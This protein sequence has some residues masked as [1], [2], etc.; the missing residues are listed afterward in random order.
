M[1]LPPLAYIFYFIDDYSFVIYI[2]L[3]DLK[4]TLEFILTDED[5][6]DTAD[7]YLC[8]SVRNASDDDQNENQN[9]RSNPEIN[10]GNN[11]NN[12][13][14]G[15]GSISNGSDDEQERI[16]TL[17]NK[18]KLCKGYKD[19]LINNNNITEDFIFAIEDIFD[20][21]LQSMLK[22][23]S[24]NDILNVYDDIVYIIEQQKNKIDEI[25]DQFAFELVPS[26]VR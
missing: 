12:N 25:Y 11:D 19:Y 3:D 26:F 20:I 15:N 16:Q 7:L 23:E 2:Y 6:Y 24:K 17:L 10:R 9:Y 21:P 1:Q 13:M 4:Q 8:T 18:L 5:C 22:I 14:G